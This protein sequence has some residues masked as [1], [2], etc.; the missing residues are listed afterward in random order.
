MEKKRE[1]LSSGTDVK[2]DWW[3]MEGHYSL[4]SN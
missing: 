1:N 2:S 3:K 4:P